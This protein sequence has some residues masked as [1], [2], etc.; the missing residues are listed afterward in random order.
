M[1][2][3]IWTTEEEDG[4]AD[5]AW[6]RIAAEEARRKA[7]QARN[8]KGQAPKAPKPPGSGQNATR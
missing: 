3:E 8:A 1:P 4:A 5:A 2:E 6:D 7:E